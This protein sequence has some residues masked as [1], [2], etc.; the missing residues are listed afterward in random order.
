[1]REI[2]YLRQAMEIEEKALTSA[3]ACYDYY[4]K[5]GDSERAGL[6]KLVIEDDSRHTGAIQELIKKLEQ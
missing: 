6:I 2:T 1:M 5:V 3:K 4:Q